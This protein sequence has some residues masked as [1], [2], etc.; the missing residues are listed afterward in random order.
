MQS[1]GTA[2]D[3]LVE[4]APERAGSRLEHVGVP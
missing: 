2:G 3:R 1:G 4:G